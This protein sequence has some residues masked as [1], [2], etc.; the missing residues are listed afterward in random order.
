M[1]CECKLDY[2][3]SDKIS[4]HAGAG[5]VKVKGPVNQQ[6][7]GVLNKVLAWIMEWLTGRRQKVVLNGKKSEWG[8]DL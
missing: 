1:F 3:I 6:V 4:D 8:G 5:S 7:V 2:C